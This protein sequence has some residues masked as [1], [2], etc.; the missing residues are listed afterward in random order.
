M[1]GSVG[2]IETWEILTPEGELNR[3]IL[4]I[5]IVGMNGIEFD[6]MNYDS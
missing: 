4:N 5:H 1:N 6:V 3:K 2:N